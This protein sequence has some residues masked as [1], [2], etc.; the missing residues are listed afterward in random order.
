MG[1]FLY[2]LAMLFLART[3][4]RAIAGLVQGGGQQRV[5]GTGAR[6]PGGGPGSAAIDMGLMVRD[7]ACG[8]HVAQRSAVVASRGGERFYFCSDACRR[9]FL[10]AS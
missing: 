10:E 5:R 1:R 6:P 9:A 4:F 8:R 3:L 7:P 2:F